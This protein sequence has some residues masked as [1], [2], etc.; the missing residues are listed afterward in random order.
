M[1]V[2]AIIKRIKNNFVRLAFPE[3]IF[4][5]LDVSENQRATIT[6][7]YLFNFDPFKPHFYVV[8]LGFTSIYIIL[9]LLKYIDCRYSLEPHRQGRIT[10]GQYQ[11]AHL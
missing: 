4:T 11:T 5:R 9:F 8:K 3:S 10:E 2:F 6:K 1:S 7:T